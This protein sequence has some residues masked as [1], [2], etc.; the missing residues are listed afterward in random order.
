[1]VTGWKPKKPHRINF[2]NVFPINFT[3]EITDLVVKNLAKKNSKFEL[4]YL[5][6]RKTNSYLLHENQ[7]YE[8]PYPVDKRLDSVIP[9]R[10][11]VSKYIKLSTSNIMFDS[12]FESGNLDAAIKI[13]DG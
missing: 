2:Q 1:M 6:P 5:G 12:D 10:P 13:S 8:N 9:E 3:C 11:G 4:V 7:K